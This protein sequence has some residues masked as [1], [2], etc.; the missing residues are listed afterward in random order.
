MLLFLF[1]NTLESP[2]DY[3]HFRWRVCHNA[4]GGRRSWPDTASETPDAD[5]DSWT[6]QQLEPGV[7]HPSLCWKGNMGNHHWILCNVFMKKENSNERKGEALQRAG[8][9]Y[10]AR[11]SQE[12]VFLHSAGSLGQKCH[13][14]WPLLERGVWALLLSEPELKCNKWVPH[15]F[16]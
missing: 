8:W 7:Y 16:Y 10:T 4:R 15:D 11:L 14:K 3:E 2:R 13:N 12:T 6:F 9:F 5:W 1:P